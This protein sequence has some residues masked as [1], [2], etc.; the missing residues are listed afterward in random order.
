DGLAGQNRFLLCLSSSGN[1]FGLAS[2]D[3]ATGEFRITEIDDPEKALE[4]I[5]RISPSELLLSRDWKEAPEFQPVLEK[6]TL[7]FLTY[8]DQG[9]FEVKRAQD[10]LTNHFQV[11]S[12]IG[13]GAGALKEGIQAAGALLFYL[14]DTQKGSLSHLQ[15]LQVYQLSEYMI[16]SETTQRHLE[17]TQTLYRGTRQ[18]SLISVLDQTMTA[19]GSRKLKQWLNY[20][21]LDLEKI[22]E[23]QKGVEALAEDPLLRQFLRSHLREIYDIER[24]VAKVCLNQ[25]G[26][27]DLVALKNS[28]LRLPA[29]RRLLSESHHAHL[30]ALGAV[31]DPLPETAELIDRAILDEPALNWKDKEARI[32]RLGYDSQLD[33]YLTISREGKEWIARLEAQERKR[34]GIN[35]LKIG[36]NRIFGYYIEVSRPNLSSVPSDYERKQTLVNGERFLTPDLKKYEIMVL[37]AEE[38]RWEL[39]V[40]LFHEVRKKVGT[41]SLRL[42]KTAQQI[43]DLDVLASLAQTA[44]ENRYTKP[45]LN[46]SEAIN[47]RESRHPVIEKNLPAQRFVPNSI[48]L[49]NEEQQMIIITGPNMAGKSTILRQAALIVLL[50]QMGSFVPA[51]SA[52]IGLVDQIFT[53]VGASDDLSSGQSTFMVE[54]QETAQ[55]LH[56]ATA[57]SLVLL[58]E[59]GRGT[60]TFD[61]LSIAWSVAE[62]LHDLK[63]K[64][65]KTLF[66][67]HYHELTDLTQTKKRVKNYHVSVKE[68]NQKIIFL[69]KLQ[70]GGTNRSFGIQV[71]RLAGLP[72]GV[73]DRAREVLKNL[74]K[75]ELDFWGLPSLASSHKSR[76]AH[77]AQL[78]LFSGKRQRVEER[79][80]TLSIDEMSPL[81]ALLTLKELKDVIEES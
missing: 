55:I 53:R 2:V 31:I 73:V 15:T 16:L 11:H 43:S 30:Q 52:E 50:A 49:D 44:Q 9:T 5:G 63:D 72:Q 10:L 60:S 6:L 12:L 59:I 28:L 75:G 7:Y 65:V 62:Y 22:L 21:L 61:G 8:A 56:Q 81:Q 1:R 13:F 35:S 42:Q 67:T 32:V 26:P 78:E 17:L 48:Y 51:E 71:A 77:P 64:G 39:E 38:K 19:M 40:D 80:K 68:Y 79:I 41:E 47:L 4:E 74:E 14:M 36:Y 76:M 57:K 24:L 33:Q 23:R 58:D 20:P 45:V 18:G 66:A 46:Q 54:M 37:E 29:I 70:E 34:T 69:R 25:A 27:R 3:L